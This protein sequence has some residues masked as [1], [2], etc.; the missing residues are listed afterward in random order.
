MISF[1]NSKDKS[2]SVVLLSTSA[3]TPPLATSV[4]VLSCAAETIFSHDN[5]FGRSLR[6]AILRI[7]EINPVKTGCGYLCGRVIKNICLKNGSHVHSTHF[8]ECICQCTMTFIND[9]YES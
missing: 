7:R 8:M 1:G 5:V 2:S 4:K 3:T 6:A 9:A